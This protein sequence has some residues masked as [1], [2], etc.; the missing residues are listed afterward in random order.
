MGTM[1][2]QPQRSEAE[3]DHLGWLAQQVETWAMDEAFTALIAGAKVCDELENAAW[4]R[5][6][7]EAIRVA[8]TVL[9][10]ALGDAFTGLRNAAETF[11]ALV[12]AFEFDWQED[13][14]A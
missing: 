1:T 10:D 7:H 14:A 12:I 6:Q 2:E 5:R 11:S 4:T 13:G 8:R 3:Q 9:D